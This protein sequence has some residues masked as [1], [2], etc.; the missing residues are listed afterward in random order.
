MEKNF[1]EILDQS[2]GKTRWFFEKNVGVETYGTLVGDL[3]HVLFSHILGI[4]IP[5]D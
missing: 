4:V 5:I 2:Y 1:L 3:E